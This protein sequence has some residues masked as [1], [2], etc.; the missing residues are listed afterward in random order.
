MG[1]GVVPYKLCD[2]HFDCNNFAFDKVIRGGHEL[3]PA[4][5]NI[6]GFKLHPFLF[7][8][9][10]HMWARIEENA[11]VRIGID[12]APEVAV[13]RGELFESMQEENRRAATS[14]KTGLAG[15]VEG[16]K[17]RGRKDG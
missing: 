16:I 17:P 6:K 2:F 7:Y 5:V 4:P 9:A 15:L 11:Q 1:A 13:Y 10:C 3:S 14:P 12:A 8:N